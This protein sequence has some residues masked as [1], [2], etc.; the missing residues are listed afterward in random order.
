MDEHEIHAG[1]GAGD[2]G[3]GGGTFT[4]PV[5]NGVGDYDS[6]RGLTFERAIVDANAAFAHGQVYAALSR[7]KTSRDFV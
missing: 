5:E 6:C 1:R 3:D 7:C 2:H 4:V